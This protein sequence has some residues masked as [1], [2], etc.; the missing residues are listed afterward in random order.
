VWENLKVAYLAWW[1][2]GGNKCLI[3]IAQL[4]LIILGIKQVDVPK[5]I[6]HL[7]LHSMSRG[8]KRLFVCLFKVDSFD[9]TIA[10]QNTKG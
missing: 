10:A 8:F 7:F 2:G 4:D 5:Q 1:E 6:Y 3:I 9:L